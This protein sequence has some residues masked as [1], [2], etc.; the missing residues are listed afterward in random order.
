MVLFLPYITFNQHKCIKKT[1]LGYSAMEEIHQLCLA[2]KKHLESVKSESTYYIFND[3]KLRNKKLEIVGALLDAHTPLE[4]K[5]ILLD[6]SNHPLNKTILATNSSTFVWTFI[7]GFFT[8]ITFP[9][10]LPALIAWSWTMRGTPYF[11]KPDGEILVE[12]LLL[13]TQS[14]SDADF[15][16][17]NFMQ[18]K[19]HQGSSDKE[20][21]PLVSTSSTIET[22]SSE[23]YNIFGAIYTASCSTLA[24]FGVTGNKKALEP[25]PPSEEE[26]QEYFP[27]LEDYSELLSNIDA[28][29]I[30]ILKVLREHGAV[31]NSIEK[32]LDKEYLPQT[33]INH[34]KATENINNNPESF[35]HSELS[36]AFDELMNT[37]PPFPKIDYLSL[38][39]KTKFKLEMQTLEEAYEKCAE[40][41]TNFLTVAE[42]LLT[43]RGIQVNET[44]AIFEKFQQAKDHKKTLSMKG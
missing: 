20:T 35:V 40:H 34:L 7:V 2:Y 11:L 29:Y 24:F 8:I 5:H 15:A 28:D 14:S 18:D 3:Y 30:I 13:L 39:D 36:K 4:V 27:F 25:I 33:K 42:E 12:K 22:P 32:H 37:R 43:A 41:H 9:I 26:Q 6:P 10:S 23:P 16:G 19:N 17:G 38:K 31:L 44:I 21:T 1:I